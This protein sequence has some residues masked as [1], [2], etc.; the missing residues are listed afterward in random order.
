MERQLTLG[1]HPAAQAILPRPV[2]RARALIKGWLF[3]PSGS[4]AGRGSVPGGVSPLHCH[5]FWCALDHVP[6]LEGERFVILPRLQWL[7]PYRAPVHG[8]LYQRQGLGAHLAGQF[9][10]APAPVLVA[11]VVEQGGVLVESARG[12]I[13]PDDWELRAQ[14]RAQQRDQ[15]THA[16]PT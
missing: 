8:E 12:F 11:A 10:A 6:A 9:A 4:G 1:E 15:R 13:V 16:A 3:Y 7:A 5:G 14:Q 2:V